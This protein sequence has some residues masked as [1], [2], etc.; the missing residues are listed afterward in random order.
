MDKCNGNTLWADGIQ[1][2]VDLM[3]NVYDVFK[4]VEKGEEIPAD[5]QQ[6]PLIWTFDV[7]FDG[8]R[9]ACCVAGGHVTPD[10][11][12]DLY[13]GVVDLETVRIA[14]V[15]AVLMDL[16]VVAADIGSAYLEAYTIEKVYV[17]AGPEFGKLQGRKLIVVRALYGLKSSGAL[18]HQKMADTL[19][20]MG[21]TPCK[22]DYN[23]WA[24]QHSDHYEYV[25]VIVD[26]LLVFS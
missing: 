6:I 20:K 17:F 13:S 2:E 8:C 9:Q 23:V 19:T 14:F 10:L 26:D 21:F 18:W 4:L 7:K 16:K 24:R 22:A 1:Q 11:E 3:Y 25:A 5:Y 15:A 12:E